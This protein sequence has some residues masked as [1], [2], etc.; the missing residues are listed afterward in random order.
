[1]IWV[2]SGVFLF[3]SCV[4]LCPPMC[5]DCSP[6]SLIFNLTSL[7]RDVRDYVANCSISAR[8]QSNSQQPSGLLK[9]L[10]TPHR[11]WSQVAL[12]F[13]TR[14]P[15]PL[16]NRPVLKVRSFCC[17]WEITHCYQNHRTAHWSCFRLHGIPLKIVLDR[18]PQF[19][20]QVWK[21]FT[22]VGANVS[23]SSRFHLPDQEAQSRDGIGSVLLWHKTQPSGPH[24]SH[25]ST[26]Y[27]TTHSPYLLPS[28]TFQRILRLPPACL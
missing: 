24:S 28:L 20:S 11:P 3:G 17:S 1:M 9:L 27:R 14:L 15:S 7:E 5:P 19:N 22:A 8:S 16:H 2:M 4:L 21:I 18:G 6:P 25:E 13:I 10:A 23:L 26:E 12:D